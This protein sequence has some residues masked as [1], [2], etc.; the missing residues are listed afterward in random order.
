MCEWYCRMCDCF[1]PVLQCHF[2]YN[3]D[4]LK[5]LFSKIYFSEE[6][7]NDREKEA[8]TYML[9][10]DL[11][12]DCEEKTGEGLWQ[13]ILHTIA[14]LFSMYYSIFIVQIPSIS[15][16]FFPFS[17]EQRQYHLQGLNLHQHYDFHMKMFYQLHQLVH[18]Q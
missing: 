7:S 2:S 18:F 13:N 9:F 16:T 15:R 17:Q 12:Y 5:G 14:T 10:L 11:V 1:L 4:R 8:A 6:G 3:L